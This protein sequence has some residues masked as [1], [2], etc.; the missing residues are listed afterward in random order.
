MNEDN[1]EIYAQDLLE[2]FA[3]ISAKTEWSNREI[4]LFMFLSEING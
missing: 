3:R 1:A 2:G 4:A